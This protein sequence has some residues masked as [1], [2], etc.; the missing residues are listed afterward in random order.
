MT[1][2]EPTGDGQVRRKPRRRSSARK[3]SIE[4]EN[5][6]IGKR[7]RE[8]REYHVQPGGL[9][10]RQFGS[11]LG[12]TRGAVAHWERGRGI[13]RTVCQMIAR[14]FNANLEWLLLGGGT[15]KSVMT[16]SLLAQAE[17]DLPP[18]TMALL[19][20]DVVRLVDSA[21]REAGIERA[22]R[23]PKKKPKPK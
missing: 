16:G 7:V 8:F 20:A 22:Q 3:S 4:A 5:K 14:E 18:H 10:Q 1:D 13:Q 15:P 6:A 9:T 19:H 12:V 21:Y 17:M 2:D 11:R 23:G